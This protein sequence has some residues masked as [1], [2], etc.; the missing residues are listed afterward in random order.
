[1]PHLISSSPHVHV[2][3][4]GAGVA[5]L[6]TAMELLRFSKDNPNDLQFNVSVIAKKF[7]PNLVSDVAG[8]LW[9]VFSSCQKDFSCLDVSFSFDHRK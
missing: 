4:L 1:M 9:F 6:S 8:G 7:S 5:G 2:V 3:V